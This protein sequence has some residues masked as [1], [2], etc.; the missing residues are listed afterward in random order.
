MD[1]MSSNPETH[2]T[3]FAITLFDLFT[4]KVQQ[5]GFRLAEADRFQGQL[6]LFCDLLWLQQIK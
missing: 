1:M 6:E 5:T 3:E 2:L 4:L